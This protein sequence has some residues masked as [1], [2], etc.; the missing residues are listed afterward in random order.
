VLD[1]IKAERK[2]R[3]EGL[4]APESGQAF[5]SRAKELLSEKV[6][7]KDVKITWEKRGCRP[8]RS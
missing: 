5:G 7:G 3:L 2:I 6:F 4:D 8:R 1:A